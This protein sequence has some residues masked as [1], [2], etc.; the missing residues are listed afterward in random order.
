MRPC[1]RNTEV[2]MARSRKSLG[3]AAPAGAPAAAL[4]Y[5][6]PWRTIN[7]RDLL[8]WLF[9]EGWDRLSFTMQH[10][11]QTNWCWA[12]V[13]TSVSHYYD[14]SSTWT[15][16]AVANAELGQTTCCANGGS[17]ACNQSWY[18]D[19]ALA[20]TG[21]FVSWSG[22]ADFSSVD[23]EI[24][25]GRPVGVRIGWSG[26]GGHF[27]VIAGYDEALLAR[28]DYVAIADPWYGSS[29]V[30]W[31]TFKTSYQGSGTWTHT[32]YTKA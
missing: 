8:Q 7:L 27:V 17:S 18:L 19:K 11:L 26:G 2:E 3:L 32:F 5:A 25:A 13:S 23:T 30:A 12:A 20:R 16:C 28:T 24:D 15:Q 21:N 4:R 6:S 9:Y 1:R 31:D 22:P 14:S 29:D 10:Q